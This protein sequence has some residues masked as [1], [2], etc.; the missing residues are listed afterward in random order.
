[1]VYEGS[2]NMKDSKHGTWGVL[3]VKVRN[4]GSTNIQTCQLCLLP[5]MCPCEKKYTP[6]LCSQQAKIRIFFEFTAVVQ[7]TDSHL[8]YCFFFQRHVIS[9]IKRECFHMRY[10]A[11]QTQKTCLSRENFQKKVKYLSS[12]PGNEQGENTDIFPPKSWRFSDNIKIIGAKT[13]CSMF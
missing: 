4:V 12:N 7:S 5:Q 9:H 8:F 10:I 13:G 6:P 2:S 11:R 1:M 3:V